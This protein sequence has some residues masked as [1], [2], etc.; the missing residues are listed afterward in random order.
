MPSLRGSSQP[1]D[2]TWVSYISCASRWLLYHQ[3]HLGSPLLPLSLW[4]VIKKKKKIPLLQIHRDWGSLW[5]QERQQARL[6]LTVRAVTLASQSSQNSG[7]KWGWMVGW[8]GCLTQ[9]QEQILPSWTER[10]FLCS[11]ASPPLGISPTCLNTRATFGYSIS[12]KWSVPAVFKPSG[13]G[14][15]SLWMRTRNHGKTCSFIE[16]PK[17]TSYQ[18]K[19][20]TCLHRVHGHV[21]PDRTSLGK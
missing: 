3:R 16:H 13:E 10:S 12:K 21:L 15:N 4:K 18:L 2:L 6:L 7:E 9:D 1:R 5:G 19:L 20:Y 8:G 11:L 14:T 17:H